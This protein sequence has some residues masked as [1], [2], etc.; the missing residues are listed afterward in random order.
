MNETKVMLCMFDFVKVLVSK[1]DSRDYKDANVKRTIIIVI[2]CISANNRSLL[3]IIIWPITTHRSNWITFP[4]PRWH[5]ACFESRYIDFKISL[6]WLK[7]IFDSQTKEQVKQKSR[8][9]ICDDFETHKTFE[10]LKFYFENN[11]ILCRLFFHISH[12]F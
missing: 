11:I 6:K 1:D 8:V 10:V 7:Y 9:L 12:K 2:E 5:Y 3:S 4:I